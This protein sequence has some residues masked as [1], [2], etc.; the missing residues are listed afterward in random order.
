MTPVQ[1]NLTALRSTAFSETYAFGINGGSLDIS[2]YTLRMQVRN[3][4]GAPGAALIDLTMVGFDDA[5]GIYVISAADGLFSVSIDKAT[6]A[7]VPAPSPGL[8]ESIYAYD[9]VLVDIDGDVLGPVLQGNFTLSDGDTGISRY[10]NL[11]T[12]E[13][14]G[15]PNF[16]AVLAA[17]LQPIAD[18]TQTIDAL[19]AAFDIDEAVGAQ[20]DIVGLWVG[21]S[22]ELLEPLVGVYFSFDTMN[23]G[24]DQGIWQGQFDPT[25]GLTSLPDD[26]YRSLLYATIGSNQWDGTIPGAYGV[27]Q[28]LFGSSEKVL[29]QDFGDMS[30]LTALMDNGADATINAL[31]TTGVIRLK[32]AGVRLITAVPSVALAPL[33]GFD[34]QNASIAG[35]DSGCW[36]T[37]FETS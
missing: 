3:Y 24:F 29:I 27:W 11:I 2:R 33:F 28:L 36:P 6:L 18:I 35:W 13:H 5:Q 8:L 32:P 20:L 26:S 17:I 10:T 23:L 19:P 14:Q 31:F 15:K 22:R 30:M 34:A 16:A 25:T 37:I 9:L 21:V 7:A 4:A 1:R 12:S